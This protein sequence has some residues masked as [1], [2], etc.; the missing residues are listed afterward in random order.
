MRIIAH[1]GKNAGNKCR[2]FHTIMPD[3]LTHIA[4]YNIENHLK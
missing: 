3:F 4:A 1:P 2:I